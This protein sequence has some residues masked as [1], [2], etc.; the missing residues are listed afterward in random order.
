[1]GKRSTDSAERAFQ[2][3]R[4][5]AKAYPLT[6]FPE[7]DLARAAAVLEA[8]G[9]TLDAIS[10]DAMRHVITQVAKIVDDSGVVDQDGRLLLD[11]RTVRALC[12]MT[13]SAGAALF[14]RMVQRGSFPQ[15]VV[16]GQKARRWV[17]Q[18][19]DEWLDARIRARAQQAT[20][21]VRQGGLL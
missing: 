21:D 15:P 2:A 20:R 10:A 1:M 6:V 3:I 12:G 9:M 14:R 11:A 5:W 13:G 7:P 4:D 18:E 8:A 16:V 17:A 19:I